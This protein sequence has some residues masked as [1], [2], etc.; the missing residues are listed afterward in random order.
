MR[1]NYLV[2][3][4]AKKQMI[5]YKRLALFGGTFNPPHL[6]HLL[7]AQEAYHRL[8]VDKIV[9]IPAAQNPLKQ[10]VTN[11]AS[12]VQRLV[13]VKLAVEDDPRMIVD[14]EE[15]QRGGLSFTVDTLRRYKEQGAAELYFLVGADAAM[16]LACWR[17]IP[18]YRELCTL[19]IYNRPGSPDFSGGLPEQLKPLKL[20]WE[21]LPVPQVDLSS[22]E[23]RRR[24][25]AGEPFDYFV[26]E[27]V[28]GYIREHQLGRQS[29]T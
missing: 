20:R 12:A 6:G 28:A 2:A 1:H 18:A 10:P 22:T 23:I 29:S 27:A 15:I 17:E 13:M 24:V 4:S 25:F 7:V 21:Y 8:P 11:F 19:A 3:S 26:P 5:A 14:C 16:E 9:F